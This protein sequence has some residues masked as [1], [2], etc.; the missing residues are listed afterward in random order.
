MFVRGVIIDDEMR[1]ERRRYIGV[2]MLEE[3]QELLM[4]M[5]RAALR[6]D[7]AIGDIEGGEQGRRTVS[8]VIVGDTL[9]IAKPERQH[10]LRAFQRLNSSRRRTARQ[11]DRA[12]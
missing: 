10:R 8:D 4:A 1:I 3:A 2:D 12:D 5:A 9:N 11:R 6:E 7:F